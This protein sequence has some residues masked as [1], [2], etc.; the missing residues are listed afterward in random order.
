MLPTKTSATK[1]ID[2]KGQKQPKKTA[3]F[4]ANT[5]GELKLA[6]L[7]PEKAE[8]PRCFKMPINSSADTTRR[9]GPQQEPEYVRLHDRMTPLTTTSILQPI[10]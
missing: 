3:L 1:D 5:T 4:S 9:P 8:K 10:E 7:V 2:V 6:L